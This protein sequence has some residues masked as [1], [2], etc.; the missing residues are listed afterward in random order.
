MTVAGA[1]TISDV[2]HGAYWLVETVTPYGHATAAPIAIAIAPGEDVVVSATI[3]DV[4]LLGSILV[5][6]VDQDGAALAGATFSLTPSGSLDPV[7]GQ[8]GL[9]CATGLL[10]DDYLV[11]ESTV[12][13]G[14][15]G[16]APQPFTVASESTCATRLEA[17]DGPDLTFVNVAL[18]GSVQLSKA[19]DAGA[20]LAGAE[21]VLCLEQNAA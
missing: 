6:K 8:I 2:P 7:T 13:D 9:F 12:P 17:G 18:P 1:C 4:R 15:T 5:Q 14:Y 19:D 16:A 3:V 20:A 11:T 10:Y 21:D